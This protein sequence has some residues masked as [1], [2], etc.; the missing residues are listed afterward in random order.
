MIEKV[1]VENSKIFLDRVC[2]ERLPTTMATDGE[3]RVRVPVVF[4]RSRRNFGRDWLLP[5]CEA[6]LY[7][8]ANDRLTFGRATERRRQ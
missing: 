8:G 6:A 2:Y 4:V 3:R 1:Q 7:R 5:G